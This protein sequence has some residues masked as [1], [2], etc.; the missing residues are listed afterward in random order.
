MIYTMTFN[1]SLDYVMHLQAFEIGKTNRSTKEEI[2]PGGKGLNVSIVLSRLGHKNQALGFS[3]GFTGQEIEKL[4][5]QE[6]CEAKFVN[7]PNALSRINVKL[8]GEKESEINGQGPI[9][10]D[11][12]LTEMLNYLEMLQDGDMLILSGSIP[13][14]LPDTIYEQI[15]ENLQHKNIKIIVD[16]TGDLL[17]NVLKYHPFLIKP[18][19]DELSDFFNA[20]VETTQDI[21]L[22]SQKLKD[23]GAINVL[24]SM[25]SEGAFLLDENGETHHSLPPSG[26]VLNTVGSGDS[27]VAG[28]VAGYL[29]T[30]N[31][32]QAFK[33]GLA[34]GSASAFLPWLAQKKDVAVLLDNPKLYGL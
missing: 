16:A 12:Q 5:L 10:P 33:L 25:G 1:P 19:K 2:Y 3:A 11:E 17:R 6:G 31:Y 13:N 9:I 8:K 24:V 26:K 23:M 18:N 21:L 34:A 32:A 7:L 4:I 30:G 27:M 20:K 22:Y 14:S 28:F 15:M 29:N